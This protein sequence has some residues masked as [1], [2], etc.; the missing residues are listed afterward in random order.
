ME[1]VRQQQLLSNRNKHQARTRRVGFSFSPPGGSGDGTAPGT[2]TPPST[3][4]VEVETVQ[5][6]DAETGVTKRKTTRV[7]RKA[8]G[9][10]ETVTPWGVTLK[11][12]VREVREVDEEAAEADKLGRKRSELRA[13][14]PE[15]VE[16][17]ALAERERARKCSLDEAGR[18]RVTAVRSRKTSEAALSLARTPPRRPNL[19][20]AASEPIEEKT[21]P[22]SKKRQSSL[23]KI[24]VEVKPN[25]GHEYQKDPDSRLM[26]HL[27]RRGHRNTIIRYETCLLFLAVD[28]RMFL[29]SLPFY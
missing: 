23:P 11:P 6:K 12:V 21:L 19:A 8:S 3:P 1:S 5:V 18:E 27:F 16:L 14:T 15:L 17:R 28:L 26:K 9:Q 7:T 22:S 13:V 20:V 10:S 4:P 25:T 2:P 29:L 24:K